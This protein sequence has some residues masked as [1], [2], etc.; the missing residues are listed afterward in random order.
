MN[1]GDT[2]GGYQLV[3]RVGEGPFGVVWQAQSP[4]GAP[5]ALKLLKTAFI[6]RPAGQAA[7]TRLLA[8]VRL[9]ELLHHDRV[10]RLYGA[11]QD[12]QH[13]A[14]GMACEF[15]EGRLVSEIRMPATAE[16]DAKSL[17]VV[18]AWFEELGEV[19][20]WLHSQGFVHGNLKPTNV[21]LVRESTGHRVKLLDLP[22]SAIGLAAPA[23]GKPSYL[24]P[25]QLRGAPPSMYSD[26]YSLA[27]MLID[28]LAGSGRPAGAGQLPPS[29]TMA[30]QRAN[31]PEPAYRFPQIL[32]FV[33]ALRL[34]RAELARPPP[35]VY[36]PY[37]PFV[38][39]A[40]SSVSPLASLPGV[41][42]PL[43]GLGAEASIPGLP[44][45]PGPAPVPGLMPGQTPSPM[46]APHPTA[47][48][49][50][51]ATPG[52]QG[53]GP[54]SPH[55]TVVP[56]GIV[57][58][59]GHGSMTGGSPS[60]VPPSPLDDAEDPV[61]VPTARHLG[62]TST[63][64]L[65]ETGEHDASSLMDTPA[66]APLA[67][68]PYNR[69]ETPDVPESSAAGGH[70]ERPGIGGAP[71][72]SPGRAQQRWDGG[73]NNGDLR[74]DSG[75][76]E[77]A[78]P[79]PDLTGPTESG[80]RPAEVR[81]KAPETN[82]SEAELRFPRAPVGAATA[83]PRV[84]TLPMLNKPD[85]MPPR[86]E[87][88]DEPPTWNYWPALIIGALL[89]FAGVM[90]AARYSQTI[91]SEP[92]KSTVVDT[93]PPADDF[94][95]AEPLAP[96]VGDDPGADSGDA[97]VAG[98]AAVKA[99]QPGEKRRRRAAGPRQ[100][101]KAKRTE[102]GA[103]AAV[104][105]GDRRNAR[106]GDGS[107]R[108]DEAAAANSEAA[109]AEAFEEA[110]IGCDEGDGE[111]CL[112]VSEFFKKSGNARAARG[113]AKRACD[114][115]ERQGCL[116]AAWAFSYRPE[117]AFTLFEKGCELKSASCCHQAAFRL[118]KGIGVN[119]DLDKAAVL[120][121]RACRLGRQDRCQTN[122]ST[123]TD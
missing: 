120:A 103:P 100:R 64:S 25:E 110:Q 84:D 36:T 87:V 55:G 54:A 79:R 20:A 19:L 102:R 63:G 1:V 68:D 24:A 44:I 104:R 26:Q 78:L 80:A 52:S 99:N 58:G 88:P 90:A 114:F 21:K 9:Q 35:G 12:A 4:R 27:K 15:V 107:R 13:S 101:G 85:P 3:K 74:S 98:E 96:P 122:T 92:I 123:S 11:I 34:V 93:V 67:T 75:D 76:F 70:D 22:W 95:T 59:G 89:V 51:G 7:F 60:S 2:V 121:E 47:S 5:L 17:A 65:P 53:Q 105:Q 38:G 8:S 42:T 6:Q 50:F 23:E 45:V 18:L 69:I 33:N 41:V 91:T 117:V 108:E 73:S 81:S 30:L 111:S 116:V 72:L 14:Y 10:A 71:G 119:R 46:A 43:G 77:S 109:D 57:P 83:R 115:G 112:E 82:G 28:V 94:P 39:A 86:L 62:R 56:A 29:L 66:I 16:Q 40:T 61:F 49:T 37:A 48:Q 97:G 106:D 31:Q 113:A 118:E 32:D